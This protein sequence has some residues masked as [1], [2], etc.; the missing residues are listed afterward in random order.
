MAAQEQILAA[1]REHE[2]RA[3]SKQTPVQVLATVEDAVDEV[4]SLA[5]GKDNTAVL[6]CGSMHIV[7][8]IMQL[9]AL[10]VRFE[11]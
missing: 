7:G 5:N 8:G 3:S 6:A 4:K 9:A 10:S 1:W 11:Q 2:K